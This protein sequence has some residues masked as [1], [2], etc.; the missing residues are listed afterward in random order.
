M[1]DYAS[2]FKIPNFSTV[3]PIINLDFSVEANSILSI[4]FG[5]EPVTVNWQEN[6]CKSPVIDFGDEIGAPPAISFDIE[7]TAPTINFDIVESVPTINFD[8][9]ADMCEPTIDLDLDSV[10]MVDN[11]DIDITGYAIEV[12]DSGIS[13][14]K[15][16]SLYDTEVRHLVVN[17]LMELESFLITRQF[18]LKS[19][20][21]LSESE[22]KLSS[23][24][25]Y[26]HYLLDLLKGE[27]F[28]QLL[29]IASSEKYVNRLVDS[30]NIEKNR[31]DKMKIKVQELQSSIST[32]SDIT[33][34][35]VPN[36]E[37]LVDETK[38]L[39]VNLESSLGKLLNKKVL[40]YGEINNI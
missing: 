38:K 24:L 9:D 19:L 25:S 14:G 27:R 8:Y 22:G 28:N 6:D 21:T 30:I 18:E 17:D 3:T 39:K 32:A 33:Q 35:N 31:I 20:N 12:Q 29:S 36:L 37:R 15:S 11:A 10:D 40:I 34:K 1:P 4:N 16:L 26:V 7:D 13:V 2:I 23:Y 5:D